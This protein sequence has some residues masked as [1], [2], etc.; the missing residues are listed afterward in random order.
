M[1]YF[2]LKELYARK[3]KTDLSGA[4]FSNSYFTSEKF[5]SLFFLQTKFC[6][7]IFRWEYLLSSMYNSELLHCHFS[8]LNFGFWNSVRKM[9]I[10]Y[11]YKS[12]KS[13][14]YLQN[15]LNQKK[16]INKNTDRSNIY[17]YICPFWPISFL[18]KKQVKK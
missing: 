12:N 1:H 2:K 18:C 11:W 14:F 10:Y 8:I 6:L 4:I 13:Y 16:Y 3:F 9:K 5:K 17:I 15:K 7:N